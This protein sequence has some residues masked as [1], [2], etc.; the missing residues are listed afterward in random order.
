MNQ[1]IEDYLAGL[2]ADADLDE[3]PAVFTGTSSAV[4]SEETAAHAVLCLADDVQNVVG[5]LYRAT[6]KLSVSSPPEDREGHATIARALVA[7]L[8]GAAA[9]DDDS[10]ITVGGAAI[11]SV[12]TTVADDERWL[13]TVE[14]VLGVELTQGD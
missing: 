12:V 3:V 1:D 14:A 5:T 13:T 11:R 9:A 7:M 8:E 10:P 4:R 6:V 2:V